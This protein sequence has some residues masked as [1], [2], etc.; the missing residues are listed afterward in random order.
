MSL[1]GKHRGGL[2]LSLWQLGTL[3]ATL[4]SRYLGWPGVTKVL[5]SL[6][7]GQAALG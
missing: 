5:W 2:P 1:E 3:M 4:I 6:A 7:W